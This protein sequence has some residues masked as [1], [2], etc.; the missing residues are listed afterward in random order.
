VVF[1]PPACMMA[2]ASKPATIMS[3]S[4]PMRMEWPERADA[5]AG[6]TPARRLTR[7]ISRRRDDV[8]SGPS[9]RRFKCNDRNR[10]PVVR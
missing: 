4:A 1:H 5:I 10:G 7:L 3:W 8:A 9:W 6:S 2:S